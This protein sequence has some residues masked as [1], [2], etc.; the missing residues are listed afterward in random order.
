MQCV[1]NCQDPDPSKRIYYEQPVW[2]TVH[3]F[4]GELACI[5]G[6]VT[7]LINLAALTSILLQLRLP[8]CPIRCL[9][10]AAPEESK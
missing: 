3:M 1:E 5:W 6:F 4:V 10:Q 2:Q 8:P 9:P 7:C